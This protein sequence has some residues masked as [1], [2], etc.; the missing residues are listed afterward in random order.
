MEA[1]SAK[2]KVE[3]G[4]AYPLGSTVQPSGINFSLYSAHAEAV[5]LCLFDSTG[6]IEQE[7]ISITHRSDDVW[8]VFVQGL[9]VNQLY[10][11]RVHGPYLPNEGHRFNSNKLLLDPYAKQFCGRLEHHD[12]IFGY[13]RGHRAGHLSFD[14][15]DSAPYVPKSVA[16]EL[17][18]PLHNPNTPVSKS[19]TIIYESHPKGVTKQ[20]PGISIAD[21]GCYTALAEPI[22]IDYLKHLGITAL[23]L[24]PIHFAA[25]EPFLV[26]KGLVNYWGYN[27]LGFFAPSLRYAKIDAIGEIRS[28]AS[29]LHDNGIE[30]ILDVVYNHT[31][32]ADEY[33][34]TLSMRGIDNL[35]YYRLA[36]NKSEYINDSG[37][38]NTLNFTNPRVIQL[39]M[40]SLRYWKTTMGVDG[41]RFDLASI[42]G[43]EDHGF[44][45]GAGLFDA[46]Q[47]DPQLASVKFFAE[48]WDVGPGGYQL[49][50]FPN[51]WSEWNDQFRDTVRRFWQGENGMLTKLADPLLGSNSIFESLGSSTEKTTNLI[52]A[53]DGFTLEDLVSYERKHNDANG[54]DDQDGHNANYS[55][56]HGIEGPTTDIEIINARD[57][58]KRNLLATLFLSQGVPLLLAG[59][60]VGNT[61]LGNNNAYCQDSPLA[62][63]D[64]PEHPSQHELSKFVSRLIAVRKKVA[65]LRQ[66]RFLHGEALDTA[67][68]F[69]NASWLNESTSPM[70]GDE[71]SSPERRYLSLLLVGNSVDNPKAAIITINDTTSDVCFQLES[72]HLPSGDWYSYIDTAN[73]AAKRSKLD[74][75]FNIK[76]KSVSLIICE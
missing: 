46:V 33:G 43:R 31:A 34:P 28:A 60:D 13:T 32:E 19:D 68:G 51:R 49:G 9:N 22:F 2:R 4:A 11:Y 54:E 65:L 38:G 57:Q 40:D 24:L 62:W 15:R 44:D 27:T 61:Q 58:H 41:F 25:D 39:T 45:S 56:N 42:L 14:T 30:L 75:M 52:T 71:W 3:P 66:T 21:Q 73:P 12:A 26:K 37:T 74:T 1:A 35:S 76:S 23:E 5:E 67:Q 48:P 6:Q 53:H 16:V 8:H 7:R 72:R 63:I 18:K 10:G 50:N 70:S 55:C 64:W 59:D 36:E 17:A 20:F 47:Q 29:A 69:S